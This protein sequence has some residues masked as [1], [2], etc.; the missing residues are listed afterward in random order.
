[1][2]EDLD[3]EELLELARVYA[4][5]WLA[6]DG[7]WFQAV[8]GAHGL[9]AA[10][11]LDAEAWGRFAPLEAGRLSRFLGLG[12]RPG[13]EGLAS[14]LRLRLYA[15]INP[16]TIEM[17][18]GRLRLRMDGCR[19]QETRRRKGL[20][21][22]ACKRVGIVEFSSFARTIDPRIETT[23]LACPPDPPHGEGICSWEFRLEE[24]SHPGVSSQGT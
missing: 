1:V 12:P 10:V 4:R 23:C 3:R 5:N 7:I 15:A 6:H 13:L 17:E 22:F 9:A 20:A 24:R 8:E 18:H 2:I 21:E 16:Q 11:D 14:A 19:V